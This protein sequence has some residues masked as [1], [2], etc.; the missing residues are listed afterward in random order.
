LDIDIEA[1]SVQLYNTFSFQASIELFINSLDGEEKMN[2]PL[3]VELPSG[4]LT[5][6]ITQRGM[7]TKLKTY[8][9]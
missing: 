3:L 9:N 8:F 1:L 2:L 6:R 4:T 5:R 7:S